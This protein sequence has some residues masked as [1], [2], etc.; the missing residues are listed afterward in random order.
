MSEKKFLSKNLQ[1][2]LEDPTMRVK[3][4]RALEEFSPKGKE[5]TE[6]QLQIMNMVDSGKTPEEVAKELGLNLVTV[7]NAYKKAKQRTNTSS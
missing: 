5:A 1:E 6:R 3:A 7:K 4:G 2:V